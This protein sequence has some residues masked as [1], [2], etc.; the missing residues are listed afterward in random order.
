MSNEDIL[1]F[2]PSYPDLDDEE[3]SWRLAK[4][5]EYQS[6]KLGPSEVVP[7][8]KGK[9]LASQLM[10]KRFFSPETDYTALMVAHS[11][12]TGKCV[13][14]DTLVQVANDE[15]VSKS[16]RI[17]DIWSA[18]AGLCVADSEG[19][20]AAPNAKINIY[21]LT[22]TNEV[23]QVP[24]MTLYRQY[25]NEKVLKV[26]I[27]SSTTTASNTVIY[28]TKK[29]R[30]LAAKPKGGEGGL[31]TLRWTTEYE[32]GDLALCCT[33]YSTPPTLATEKI[34]SISEL[35]YNGWVYDLE[36]HGTHNYF[37]EGVACHNTCVSSAIVE[38]FKDILRKGQTGKRPIP[39]ALVIV[40]N[41]GL[42]KN[43]STA[44]AYQCTAEIY[45]HTFTD[46]EL[47]KISLTV[48]DITES[49]WLKVYNAVKKTYQFVTYRSFLGKLPADDV[50]KRLYSNRLIII[51]EIHNIREGATSGDKATKDVYSN[52][53]R[54]LHVV[55]NSRVLGLSADL[56]WDQASEIA[57]HFN[58][59]LPLDAQLPTDSKFN[60]RYFNKDG[61]LQRK[62]ELRNAFRGR[63][64]YLRQM[65]TTAKREEVGVTEPW[66]NN[67]IVYPSAMS[68]FQTELS[69][70]ARTEIVYD[71]KGKRSYD[72][73]LA[74]ARDANVFVFPVFDKKG[75][76]TGGTYGSK[77]FR[78]NVILRS[79]KYRYTNPF[80]IE[81]I[82]D[83]L[84][85]L[86][87]VFAAVVH[88]IK[89]HPNE[90][91]F[92][93]DPFVAFGGSSLVNLSLILE[94]HGFSRKYTASGLKRSPTGSRN[95][96]SIIDDET[97][98]YGP[99]EVTRIL[100]KISSEEN[101]YGDLCQI[102]LGSKKISEG[103]TIG[104]AR[105][106][107]EIIP[108][109][110]TSLSSQ[111][112]GRVFRVGTHRFLKPE[113][114]YIRIF[115]HVGLERPS[116]GAKGYAKGKGYPAN[117]SFSKKETVSVE[118]Y[119]KA[120]KKEYRTAQV[121]RLI[122][123][124]SW[125]CP[126]TYG[127]N[128]LSTDQAGTRAC[129]YTSCNY[130]CDGFPEEFIDRSQE[131]WDYTIPPELVDST[132]YKL[133][134]ASDDVR[135]TVDDIVRLFGVYSTL[136]YRNILTLI[137]ADD[138]DDS[139][140]GVNSVVLQALDKVIEDSIP[141]LDR[142][143][144]R[145][146]LREEGDMYYLSDSVGGVSRYQEATY[147]SAPIISEF[148][149]TR[150]IVRLYQD[151]K[152]RNAINE[153]CSNPTADKLKSLGFESLV[154]VLESAVKLDVEESPLAKSPAV[155]LVLSE[156]SHHVLDLEG[157]AR[158]HLLYG[159]KFGQTTISTLKSEGV[160][161]MIDEEGEWYTP[162]PKEERKILDKLLKKR[163]KQ[164]SNVWEGNE[165]GVYGFKD[166]RGKF[167]IREKAQ[168][169]KSQTR[170]SV[171]YE[172][173]WSLE[174]LYGLL[175]K[176]DAFPEEDEEYSSTEKKELLVI[177]KNEPDMAKYLDQVSSYPKKKLRRFVSLKEKQ[178]KELCSFIEKELKRRNLFHT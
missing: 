99:K 22:S 120:E 78:S 36:I 173:S 100:K 10:Q 153:L 155:K 145:R 115:R 106:V 133:M 62:A 131:V 16:V 82:K 117:A 111:A 35:Q 39:P 66:T 125:D 175:V 149:P 72:S 161:R 162:E 30:L 71:K 172:A 44:V 144:F 90:V 79:K 169:G 25:V 33:D 60:V 150:D 157:G 18:Y 46:D 148:T 127:R 134:Y 2:L 112:E 55:E 23:L 137:S 176:L 77:G 53:H 136:S 126:L 32:V 95:F 86:S 91:V 93:F 87:S 156:L 142:Y 158:G 165:L 1:S 49:R 70:K 110:N 42:V 128:V 152:D 151:E 98:K 94:L 4:K 108:H 3:F 116:S 64:T 147:T 45:A 73:L 135:D 177:V 130:T 56:M 146:F 59:I 109:W 52:L 69:E 68:D 164:E 40:P 143:G 41:R 166:H 168:K 12:G 74:N 37:A 138:D 43:Y 132:N 103:Y 31:T 6:L 170:G 174:R 96:I 5:K 113:E 15:G 140:S 119:R 26:E 67:I 159:T 123:E 167:K 7:D 104:N 92:I 63:I 54:F 14:P 11:T 28:V 61:K 8:E 160:L 38:N 129:D 20:W 81:A 88:E 80:L 34:V 58:L 48:K 178:K 122:K 9:L 75:K 85:K 57:S 21:T 114:R 107:H 118:V 29:H 13:L 51:D 97:K 47:E 102:V 154:K 84:A 101:A 19:Y 24:V 105:Q 50:I 17:E 139:A 65:M 124:V 89:S 121:Y 141:I 163:K 76:I 27:S 171:C 83:D